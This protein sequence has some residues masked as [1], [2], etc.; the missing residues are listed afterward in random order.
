[1]LFLSAHLQGQLHGLDQNNKSSHQSCGRVVIHTHTHTHI[2]LLRSNAPQEGASHLDAVLD[3][4][5]VVSDDEGR[6]H[7][8][9]ELDV[10]VSFMLTLELVQQRLI[11][12]LGETKGHSRCMRHRL[13]FRPP[14]V[15]EC[16][17]ISGESVPFGF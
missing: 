7:D 4:S 2:R 9:G 14:A 1:M 12:G 8:S 10:A 11:G 3:F 6:L 16:P 15:S 17:L 13:K 5:S